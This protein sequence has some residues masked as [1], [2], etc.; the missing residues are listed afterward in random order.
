[1]TRQYTSQGAFLS[2]LAWEECQ[3]GR[4]VRFPETPSRL[5]ALRELVDPENLGEIRLLVQEK[6]E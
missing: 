4:P 2:D 6:L 3:Q 5:G 1:M